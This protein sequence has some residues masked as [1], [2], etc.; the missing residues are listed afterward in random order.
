[1]NR[2]KSPNALA[3]VLAY[4]LGRNPSEFGLVP[5]A[6]GWIKTKELLKALAEEEGWRHIRK[7]HIDEV[8]MVVSDSPIEVEGASIRARQRSNLKPFTPNNNTPL[9]L[10]ACVRNTAYPFTLGKGIIP[11]GHPYVILSDTSAMAER[12]GKRTSASPII[13]TVHVTKMSS[14]GIPILHAGGSLYI[15]EKVPP[16]CFTGPPIAKEKEESKPKALTS[17]R[18]PSPTP[19]SFLLEIKKDTPSGKGDTTRGKKNDWKRVRKR[20]NR[21]GEGRGSWE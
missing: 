17:Q 12:L 10:Y 18:G 16:D 9:Q 7:N 21:R 20:M 1:M 14:H 15:V 19:G 6:D 4:V 8:L 2:Q 3:K 5:D 11:S 13:L